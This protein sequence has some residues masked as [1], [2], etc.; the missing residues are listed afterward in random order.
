MIRQSGD[1][2]AENDHVAQEP[3]EQDRSELI[4]L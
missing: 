4:L 1:R 3:A 2:F